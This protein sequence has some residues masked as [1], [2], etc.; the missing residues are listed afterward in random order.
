MEKA[1]ADPVL[2]KARALF[3]KSGKSLDQLGQE[4][5]F[6]GETAR[7]AAWQLLNKVSDPRLSTLRRFA[8]AMGVDLKDLF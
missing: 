7:K 1:E 3:E 2:K 4:M 8:K 5:G 6:R